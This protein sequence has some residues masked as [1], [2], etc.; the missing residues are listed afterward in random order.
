MEKLIWHH[1][2]ER[3]I[4]VRPNTSQS[5]A[6]AAREKG[7]FILMMPDS[8]RK[9][10]WEHYA[11]ILIWRLIGAE[12][13]Q[14]AELMARELNEE[15]FHLPLRQISFHYQT[16]RWGSCSARGV[17]HLSHRL[18]HAPLSL[19]RA[20]ILHELAHL[21]HLDH[22]RDFWRSLGKADPDCGRRR[23]ELT[24]YGRIWGQWWTENL[25]NLRRHGHIRLGSIGGTSKKQDYRDLESNPNGVGL[26]D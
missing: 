9:A 16:G 4:V 2:E 3:Q 13:R 12:R 23:Q 18:H 17:I 24:S 10:E 1:P 11:T 7:G 19:V 25:G 14:M 6:S 20:V 21:G 5:Y 26:C 8:L 22:G 15:F